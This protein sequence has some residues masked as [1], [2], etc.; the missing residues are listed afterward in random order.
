MYRWINRPRD[1]MEPWLLLPFLFL[2]VW[3][4]SFLHT[5]T[6]SEHSSYLAG[7]RV[8]CPQQ[9]SPPPVSH[10]SGRRKRTT[11]VLMDELSG[12]GHVGRVPEE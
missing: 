4:T 8:P 9:F 6:S 1:L 5:E 10:W 2:F 11:K 12:K 3:T 7:G